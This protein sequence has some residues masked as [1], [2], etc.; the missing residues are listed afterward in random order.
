MQI[1]INDKRRQVFMS[2]EPLFERHGFRKTTVEEICRHAGISKRTFYEQFTD[3]RDLLLKLY[4]QLAVDMVD[5]FRYRESDGLTAIRRMEFFI[6][7]SIEFV[8]ARPVYRFLLEESDL[9]KQLVQATSRNVQFTPVIR[10]LTE[11]IEH[12]KRSGEFR[13]VDTDSATWIIQVLLD[14][15]Y[16]FLFSRDGAANNQDRPSLID[17]TK[18]FIV[19]GLLAGNSN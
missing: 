18:R 4:S 1:R 8:N 7:H 15:V 14:D 9:V 16:M 13:D 5:E 2:A 11:I 12:G 17:E 3:K 6:D 19:N 10:L